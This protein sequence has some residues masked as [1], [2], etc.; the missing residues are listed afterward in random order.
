MDYSGHKRDLIAAETTRYSPLRTELGTAFAAFSASGG[1]DG[2]PVDPASMCI[3]SS[4]LWN[5]CNGNLAVYY[6]FMVPSKFGA[7]Q[8]AVSALEPG[9]AFGSD[10]PPRST[11]GSRRRGSTG[12]GRDDDD[13]GGAPVVIQQSGDQA[14]AS[15]LKRAI[16]AAKAMTAADDAM[17]SLIQKHEDATAALNSNSN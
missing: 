3:M 9:Q 16:L 5:F 2:G 8:C 14:A 15:A 7:L 10:V 4:G 12:A 11:A 17:S 6:F 1:G 13:G